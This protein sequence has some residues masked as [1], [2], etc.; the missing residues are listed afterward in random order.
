VGLLK[1]NVTRDNAWRQGDG[2]R[3]P[4]PPRNCLGW[5]TRVGATLAI[6]P[7]LEQSYVEKALSATYSPVT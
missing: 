1:K 4:Y 3:R 2:K 6:A 7:V 5:D